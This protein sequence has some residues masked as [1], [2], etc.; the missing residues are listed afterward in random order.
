MASWVSPPSLTGEPPLFP[1]MPPPGLDHHSLS[2]SAT[3]AA[4]FAF[5]LFAFP[6]FVFRGAR[7]FLTGR[8]GP[9]DYPAPHVC[10]G[11]STAGSFS[12]SAGAGEV[13]ARWCLLGGSIGFSCVHAHGVPAACAKRW[14]RTCIVLPK[15]LFYSVLFSARVHLGEAIEFPSEHAQGVPK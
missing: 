6:L 12:E 7:W 1:V 15:A 5:P 8:P 3:A 2:L 13:V 10:T 14:S 4:Q 9:C 11:V